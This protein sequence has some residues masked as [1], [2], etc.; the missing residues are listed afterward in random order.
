MPTDPR[1]GMVITVTVLLCGI[2]SF[3]LCCNTPIV[4]KLESDGRV[5]VTKGLYDSVLF[6]TTAEA[7]KVKYVLC[8]VVRF[9]PL[10][11]D[12]MIAV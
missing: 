7:D 6:P 3:L 8:W 10:A 11:P 1:D 2:H 5:F 9:N 12:R 4:S